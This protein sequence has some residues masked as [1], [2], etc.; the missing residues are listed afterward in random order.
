MN[1][2]D[3][4]DLSGLVAMVVAAFVGFILP[5][6]LG[7]NRDPREGDKITLICKLISMVLA[8]AGIVLLILV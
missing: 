4:L 3:P 8:L 7:R 6:I 5:M 2:T 1:W